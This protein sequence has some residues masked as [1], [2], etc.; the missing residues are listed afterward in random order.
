MYFA[1]KK[2]DNKTAMVAMYM[3]ILSVTNR[4]LHIPPDFSKFNNNWIGNKL[5]AMSSGYLYTR[6][7]FDPQATTLLRYVDR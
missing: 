7:W 5:V 4:S 1:N 3:D 2:E 6:L